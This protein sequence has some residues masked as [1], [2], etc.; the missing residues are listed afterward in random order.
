MNEQKKGNLAKKVKLTQ[1]NSAHWPDNFSIMSDW[2]TCPHPNFDIVY[3]KHKKCI[4]HTVNAQC[5]QSKEHI[6]C[7]IIWHP[8]ITR[9]NQTDDGRKGD[10]GRP[11]LQPIHRAV[12]TRLASVESELARKLSVGDRRK[13]EGST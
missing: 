2:V 11:A 3:N 4:L 7:Y 5:T 8:F 1:E 10:E 9:E 6:F 12:E 13:W